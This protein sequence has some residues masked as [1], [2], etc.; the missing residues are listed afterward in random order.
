L[1]FVVLNKTFSQFL[2]FGVLIL[3]LFVVVGKL[4]LVNSWFFGDVI[5]ELSCFKFWIIV[6]FG[7]DYIKIFEV[8]GLKLYFFI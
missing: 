8:N 1:L 5:F 7:F 3:V 2:E 4:N 6:L